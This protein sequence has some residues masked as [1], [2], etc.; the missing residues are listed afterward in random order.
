MWASLAL[1]FPVK[2]ILKARTPGSVSFE[3]VGEITDFT[4]LSGMARWT[5]KVQSG[6]EFLPETE[7]LVVFPDGAEIHISQSSIKRHTGTCLVIEAPR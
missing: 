5:T 1:K 4:V 2:H 3:D 7:F 6:L